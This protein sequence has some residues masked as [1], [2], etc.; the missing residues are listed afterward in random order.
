MEQLSYEK[1]LQDLEQF[2]QLCSSIRLQER[3]GRFT[4]YHREIVA[5]M[6]AI[7]TRSLSGQDEEQ[8]D[9]Y[10]VALMEGMEVSLLLPYLLQCEP[11]AVSPKLKACLRGPFMP[12]DE[13]PT[14]HQN[15]PRNIQFELFLASILWRSGFQPVLGEHPD[16]KCRVENKWFFFECKRLFSTSPQSLRDRIREAAGQIRKNRT[17]APPGTRGIIAISL[18]RIFNPSQAAL[19]MLNEQ[20]GRDEIA[21]WLRH[22]ADEVRDAWEP[23]F[24]KKIVGIFFY[25]ASAFENFEADFYT[26]GRHFIGHLLTQ[27]GS[28]DEI[29]VRKLVEAM[30]A[31]RY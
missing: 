16:I 9:K 7:K 20:Q 8:L 14:S 5:L 13:T 11:P 29:A 15:H 12:N 28:R 27:K 23:L 4:Q 22:K 1:I 2:L 6:D 10:R 30:E 31:T 18:A 21:M 26:Y 19:H 17:K 3:T 25:A 24:H